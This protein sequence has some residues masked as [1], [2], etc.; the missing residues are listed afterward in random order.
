MVTNPQGCLIVLNNNGDF[1]VA[2]SYT[3]EEFP[4]SENIYSEVTVSDYTF[5]K[6]FKESEVLRLKLN[7]VA[8]EN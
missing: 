1:L 2:D 7:I 5:T 4:N 8:T 6:K 3:L